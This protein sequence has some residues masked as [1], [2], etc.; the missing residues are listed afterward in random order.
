MET[1]T[2]LNVSWFLDQKKKQEEDEKVKQ[3]INE[4]ERISAIRCFWFWNVTQHYM[5]FHMYLTPFIS[6][7]NCFK[8]YT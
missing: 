7:V 5:M 1:N 6:S 4:M 3:H 2:H 8:F